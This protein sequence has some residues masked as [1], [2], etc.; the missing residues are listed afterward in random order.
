MTPEFRS[1]ETGT[2]FA[3]RK[4][5]QYIARVEKLTGLTIDLVGEIAEAAEY[6]MLEG[7][8]PELFVEHYFAR[9]DGNRYVPLHA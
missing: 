1:N 3:E 7:L 9:L 8:P 5:E 6:E 4:L 2:T